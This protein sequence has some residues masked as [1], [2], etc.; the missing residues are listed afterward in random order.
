[1]IQRDDEVSRIL[2]KYD[3][4]WDLVDVTIGGKSSIDLQHLSINSL[5]NATKFLDLYGYDISNSEVKLELKNIFDE[6]IKFIEEVLI[7]DPFT[8]KTYLKIPDEIKNEKDIRNLIL[9]SSN[10]CNDMQLWSCAI[11][12]VM[13]TIAHIN[14]DISLKFFPEIQRQ[15]LSRIWSAIYVNSDGE[16]FFGQGD[17]AIKI[18]DVEIKAKKERNSVILKLLH[19]IENVAADVFDNI[20]VRII[21]YDKLDVMLILRF[22]R[23]SGIFNFCNIKPSRS[24]NHL[25]NLDIFKEIVNKYIKKYIDGEINKQEFEMILKEETELKASIKDIYINDFNKYSSKDYKTI[26]F[27]IRQMIRMKYPYDSPNSENYSFFFPY[28]MQ[29]VD[30]KTHL[31]NMFGRASHEKYKEKQ[32]IAARK[33]VLGKLLK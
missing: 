23:K 18:Y 30:L 27:T 29:I 26:Q 3:F 16:K 1:M 28:E 19:K 24:I 15:I 2:R 5:D 22:L 21:T 7:P 33:R 14:N 25:I 6:A 17:D 12:R 31:E 8:K 9:I 4:N 10:R 13:H 32:L 11:L 20:G